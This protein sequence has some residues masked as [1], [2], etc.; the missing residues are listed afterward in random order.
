MD[1]GEVEEALALVRERKEG[2]REEGPEQL[3]F[4]ERVDDQGSRG[5]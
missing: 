5:D 3:S 1:W 2:R 4:L